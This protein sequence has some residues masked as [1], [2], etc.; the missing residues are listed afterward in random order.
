MSLLR[1][2]ILY[3]ANGNELELTSDS[4]VPTETKKTFFTQSPDGTERQVSTQ[5]PFPVS[6]GLVCANDIWV[7]ESDMG[8][9]SGVST[10]LFD[11]LHTVITNDTTDNPKEIT[12]HFGT[13][14]LSNL[15]GIGAYV[16]NGGTFSNVEIQTALSDGVFNTVVDES[17]DTTVLQTKYYQLPIN[18][19]FNAI[20][21]RFHTTNSIII[22]NLI[23]PKLKG[24]IS[25][26]QGVDPDNNVM[27]IGATVEGSL[28][29]STEDKHFRPISLRMNQVVQSGL[30]LDSDTVI[31][32]R[33]ITMTTGHGL[34]SNDYIII[35]QE[36]GEPQFFFSKII[37]VATDVLTLDTL[38]PY[39]F[40][41]TLAEVT[42]YDPELNKDGST[43]VY[44]A[45]IRNPFSFSIDV[46]RFIFHM[47]DAS[48]MDDGTFG[49]LPALTNGI[50]LRKNI[51]GE[52]N[53]H[54]WNCKTNGNIG[55]LSFDK[56]YDDKAPAGVYGFSSRLTYAGPSKHGVAIRLETGEAIELLIQDDLTGLTSFNIMVEGHFNE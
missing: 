53:Q 25:R 14:V 43:T 40:L 33:T 4:N 10:D 11:N 15:I 38:V 48:A 35:L 23:V 46:T 16:T 22:S 24:T 2:F 31:D 1:K 56:E 45:E 7:A 44:K 30:T 37:S 54:Y 47:T 12:I 6:D 36:N 13:T 18:A 5:N 51:P 41:S 34:V 3:D 49:G 42:Q 52:G 39:A 28:K 29:V 17:T 9:F 19:G 27:D 8:D 32:S 50:A 21:L 26:L 55:E 20:K